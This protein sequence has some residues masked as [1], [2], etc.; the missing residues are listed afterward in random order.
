MTSTHTTERRA[1]APAAARWAGRHV[2]V[3]CA[4]RSARRPAQGESAGGTVIGEHEVCEEIAAERRGGALVV[5]CAVEHFQRE[6]ERFVRVR[7]CKFHEVDAVMADRIAAED[8]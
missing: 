8:V 2:D 1:P 7:E 6:P 4:P 3:R 5:D